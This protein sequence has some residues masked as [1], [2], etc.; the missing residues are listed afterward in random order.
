MTENELRLTLLEPRMAVCRLHRQAPVPDW[1]MAGDFWSVTRTADELSVV[2][3]ERSVPDGVVAEIGWRALKIEGPLDFG[4]VGVLAGLTTALAEAEISI[5][6]VSTY[7][8]DYLLVK[9]GDVAEAVRV[10]RD[11]RYVVD[12]G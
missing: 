3:A 12:G 11:S 1:G 5:F 2:C 10:L 7:D 9:S 6:A 4:M 8:T